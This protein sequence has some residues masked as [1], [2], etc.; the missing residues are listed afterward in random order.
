MSNVQSIRQNAAPV[1]LDLGGKIRTIV[2]DLN[3][4]AELEVR[5]G[6]VDAAMEQLNEGK[7]STVRIILWA[8]LIHEEAVID[9]STGEPI[10]YNITPY[11]VGSWITMDRLGTI[12]DAINRAVTGSLPP[13]DDKNQLV[14]DAPIDPLTKPAEVVLTKEEIKAEQE[15]NV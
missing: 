12:M 1:K 8:G 4:F 2:Y 15:K 14:E 10:K 9:E 11:Q 13:Q 3:A 6:S 7:V 5:Y